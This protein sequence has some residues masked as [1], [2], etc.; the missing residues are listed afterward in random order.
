MRLRSPEA[1]E[2]FS[3]FSDSEAFTVGAG[4]D[5]TGMWASATGAGAVAAGAGAVTNTVGGDTTE[6][7]I[8]GAAGAG[9]AGAGAETA[10][11]GA[12]LEETNGLLLEWFCTISSAPKLRR[13]I[14]NEVLMSGDHLSSDISP[15][16]RVTAYTSVS[17]GVLAA[18]SLMFII[19]EVVT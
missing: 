13:A 6:A 19:E 9:A 8:A 1:A 14:S 5:V 11:T 17:E 3:R 16:R 15:E 4:A 10:A 2:E 12:E 7:D 18:S